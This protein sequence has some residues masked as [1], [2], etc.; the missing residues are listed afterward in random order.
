[1]TRV[2]IQGH[3]RGRGGLRLSVEIAQGQAKQSVRAQ[4]DDRVDVVDLD[5]FSFA[6]LRQGLTALVT[7][8]VAG[9]GRATAFAADG[10][11][12]VVSD[13]NADG[14]KET[15]ALIEKVGSIA[16]LVTADVSKSDD[17]A[18]L[19]EQTVATFGKNAALSGGINTQ[20]VDS[21]ADQ[22]SA[23]TQ[24]SSEMMSPLHLM[25]RIRTP[26]DVAD[27]IAWLCSKQA[28]FMIGAAIPVDGGYVAQ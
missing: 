9:I 8:A 3:E 28:P 11:I 10:T 22:S 15:D 26:Q 1:M 23:G 12:V 4:N 14:G 16:I 7:G 25:G 13:V 24:S 27:L 19:T 2:T 17:V 21:L 5:R 18:K 6:Q 20:M